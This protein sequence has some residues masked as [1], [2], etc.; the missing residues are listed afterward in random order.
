[1]VSGAIR[2]LHLSNFIEFF[3][4][5][6]RHNTEVQGVH[7]PYTNECLSLPAYPGVTESRI[8]QVH[9]QTVASLRTYLWRV[10][11]PISG[12]CSQESDLAF[13]HPGAVPSAET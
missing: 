6:L 10:S 5:K 1:M 3:L 11:A 12:C 4:P 13:V 9:P 2:L 7:W 8:C